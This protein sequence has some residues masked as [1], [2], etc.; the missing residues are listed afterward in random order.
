MTKVSYKGVVTY[1]TAAYYCPFVPLS[2]VSTNGMFGMVGID[3][4]TEWKVF[5][6]ADVV[7]DW[8]ATQPHDMWDVEEA[9]QA[10]PGQI[11]FRI[12]PDLESWMIL[13]WG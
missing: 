12:S 1:D 9:Q 11:L 8:I 13:K 7:M 6:V 10:Y 5:W 4:P 2:I 3:M